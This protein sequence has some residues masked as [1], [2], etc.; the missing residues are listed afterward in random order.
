MSLLPYRPLPWLRSGHLQTLMVGLR[1]GWRPPYSADQILVD[2]PDG[3]QMVVHAERPSPLDAAAPTVILIHGLGGDHSSPYLQ[4]IAH[5]LAHRGLRVWRVD[6]RGCGA[7]FDLAWRPPHA[8]RSDDVAAVVQLA[9]RSYPNSPIRLVGFSLSGN[10][11]L[12]MLGE[13]ANGNSAVVPE[14]VEQAIAIAPP[15][16]LSRCADRIDR[17]DNHL[18][19]RY[20]LKML[21][22]QVDR[23]RAAWQQWAKMPSTPVP[24]TIRQFDALYTAPLSG[25]RDTEHYY[26]SSSA[27][28]LMGQIKTPTTVLVDK[29]DPI[30]DPRSFSNFTG[31]AS[32]AVE[33]TRH[34]GH[35]GYFGRDDAGKP[36]RWMELY[37]Q[38]HLLRD[39]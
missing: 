38:H 12:K 27:R 5:R 39:A 16:E 36:I 34:G 10:I 33:W 15:A 3:E 20:Y 9:R 8:G 19:T 14:D 24:R 29:H 1:C 32:V 37:V 6:L 7:G 21:A 11:V 2:L 4:R 22:R 35:M 13:A 25:F 23:R 31:T 30:I 18:Y 17:L 26:A 28:P